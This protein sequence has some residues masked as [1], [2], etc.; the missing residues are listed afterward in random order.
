MKYLTL[1]IKIVSLALE[2]SYIRK[3]EQKLFPTRNTRKKYR[4]LLRNNSITDQERKKIDIELAKAK[5][6]ELRELKWDIRKHRKVDI[7]RES[8]AAQLAYGFLR[9]KKYK[10]LEQNVSYIKS[11]DLNIVK[12][13]RI[14]HKFG[15]FDQDIEEL[16]KEIEKWIRAD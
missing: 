12:I 7:S 6:T 1:K 16:E 8:R 13:A 10:S 11:C 14:A 15:N 9:G 3:Q 2:A 5:N 4:K